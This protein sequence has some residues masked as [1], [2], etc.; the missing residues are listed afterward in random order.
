MRTRKRYAYKVINTGREIL[1]GEKA[2]RIVV[3]RKAADKKEPL[4]Y[5]SIDVEGERTS[6]EPE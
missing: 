2:R 4:P 1:E 6:N 3:Y 5:I